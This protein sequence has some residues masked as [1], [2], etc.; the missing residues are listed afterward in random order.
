MKQF[1][2]LT[3]KAEYNYNK[4]R[5]DHC[6]LTV[7]YKRTSTYEEINGSFTIPKNWGATAVMQFICSLDS[8]V[9]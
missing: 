2:V 5:D 8:V 1:T 6:E 9:S 3:G 4:L 7:K